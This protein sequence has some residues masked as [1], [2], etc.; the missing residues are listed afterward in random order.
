M[1]QTVGWALNVQE[2][3]FPAVPPSYDDG[4][5]FLVRFPSGAEAE[6]P[7]MVVLPHTFMDRTGDKTVLKGIGKMVSTCVISFHPNACDIG[8][9]LPDMVAIRDHVFD[10]DAVVVAPEY[11]GYGLLSDYQPTVDSIELLAQATWQ[12]CRRTLCF[13]PEQVVL[14]GRS[15]GTGPAAALAKARAQRPAN[16]SQPLGAL[17]L[18]APFLSIQAIVQH[19]TNSL[20]ASLLSPM[21]EVGELVKDPGLRDVPLVV[22]HPEDDEVIPVEQGKAVIEGA[23]SQAKCP[24][25]VDGPGHNFACESRH[26]T[27]VGRFLKMHH[28]GTLR[29][30]AETP[31]RSE[32]ELEPA[33]ALPQATRSSTDGGRA[34]GER[35]RSRPRSRRQRGRDSHE[36]LAAPP[37]F[38]AS[39]AAARLCAR[40]SQPH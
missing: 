20:V 8:D 39:A 37:S 15:I 23:S 31:R 34:P 28:V 24:L 12:Y 4:H 25:W 36:L 14:W 2:Y 21:W 3:V 40:C 35:P 26:L 38:V 17:V 1:G 30:T 10:G 29:R 22:L 6:V 19:H 11:T 5:E 32:Y 33:A 9:C 16:T 13:A 7:A 18:V 27:P